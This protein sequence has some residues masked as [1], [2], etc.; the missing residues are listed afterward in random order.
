MSYAFPNESRTDPMGQLGNAL[1]RMQLNSRSENL[2]EEKELEVGHL[3]LGAEWS[4]VWLLAWVYVLFV[5]SSV[6]FAID[7][8]KNKWINKW[9]I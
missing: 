6:S 9:N 5:W 2:L 1:S 3:G 7:L 8:G 4:D